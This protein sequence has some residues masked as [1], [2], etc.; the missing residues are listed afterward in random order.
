MIRTRI[1]CEKIH[2]YMY[3][4]MPQKCVYVFCHTPSKKNKLFKN[5]EADISKK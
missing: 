3:Q 1:T 4:I 2:C 5:D